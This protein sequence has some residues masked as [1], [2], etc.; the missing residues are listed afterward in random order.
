[1]TTLSKV[2]YFPTNEFKE[3]HE[4]SYSYKYFIHM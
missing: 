3:S 2:L 4:K 1:M